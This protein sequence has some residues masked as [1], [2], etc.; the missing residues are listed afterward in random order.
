MAFASIYF[1]LAMELNIV[2]LTGN[3]SYEGLFGDAT[4]NAKLLERV[5]SSVAIALLF[6][7]IWVQYERE[8]T[9]QSEAVSN[10]IHAKDHL[11][12]SIREQLESCNELLKKDPNNT[13]IGEKIY[14]LIELLLK[15]EQEN[16]KHKRVLRDLSGKN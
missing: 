7:G 3:E 5:F 16:E 9:K 12:V 10:I 11:I 6:S 13:E 8:R 1:G 15:T 14:R 2:S 4:F